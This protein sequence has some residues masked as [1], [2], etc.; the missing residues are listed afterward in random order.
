[1][2]GGGDGEILG[3]GLVAAAQTYLVNVPDPPS[4]SSPMRTL[5]LGRDPSTP[6][7]L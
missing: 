1:M 6:S 5:P 7:M 3:R 2:R 4:M